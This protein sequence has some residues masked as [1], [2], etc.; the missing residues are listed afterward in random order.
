MSAPA[1]CE[2]LHNSPHFANYLAVLEVLCGQFYRSESAACSPVVRSTKA[3]YNLATP[4]PAS[5]AAHLHSLHVLPHSTPP[6]G[7]DPAHPHGIVQLPLAQ[8][9]PSAGLP[10]PRPVQ[11]GTPGFS[12]G[13]RCGLSAQ[14]CRPA[15]ISPSPL[16][17]TSVHILLLRP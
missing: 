7:F 9:P 17:D 14:C 15:S 6:V 8:P 13:G 2:A 5:C 16:C 11:S 10:P 4:R 1:Q 12:P 3:P